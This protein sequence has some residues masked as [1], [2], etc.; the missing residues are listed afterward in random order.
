LLLA[1]QADEFRQLVDLGG[2]RRLAGKQPGVNQSILGEPQLRAAAAADDADGDIAPSHA[3]ADDLPT[4]SR[5]F[6]RLPNGKKLSTD[7]VPRFT[8]RNPKYRRDHSTTDYVDLRARFRLTM[9]P[10]RVMMR[11]RLALLRATS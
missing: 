8:M 7:H 11:V 1:D 4:E 9:E 6:G 2:R 10:A 5:Q 3:V